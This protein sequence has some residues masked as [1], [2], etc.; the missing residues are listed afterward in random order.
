MKVITKEDLLKF[1]EAER[2]GIL[3]KIISGEYKYI[4]K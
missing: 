1:T 3:A 4:D 2:W